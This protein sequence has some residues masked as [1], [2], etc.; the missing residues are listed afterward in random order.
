[1]DDVVYCSIPL[2]SKTS[3]METVL[4]PAL[5]SIGGWQL[6]A[7]FLL[8]G[9]PGLKGATLPNVLSTLQGCREREPVSITGEAGIHKPKLLTHFERTLK[10]H[11]IPGAP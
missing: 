5:D 2:P 8:Q 10:G 4:T 11:S 7:E 3:K 6:L 9:C 1:M